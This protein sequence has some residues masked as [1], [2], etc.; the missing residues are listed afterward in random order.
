VRYSKR[1]TTEISVVF[2]WYSGM[3][4]NMDVKE[5]A[6]KASKVIGTTKV[7]ATSI[8]H[9]DV[10]YALHLH[11]N[12][13][14]TETGLV[15]IAKL[16]PHDSDL[17]EFVFR[18]DHGNGELDV[19]IFSN[20]KSRKDWDELGYKGHHTVLVNPDGREYEADI[21]I[22]NRQIFKGVIKVGLVQG[23]VLNETITLTE[24]IDVQ[25]VD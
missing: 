17:P 15:T 16:V 2:L 9:K 23:L 5:F 12:V 13:Y 14:A 7:T 1:K 20:G 19:D 3:L 8:Q 21:S 10:G 22:H 6:D 4:D 18:W 25:I 11:S 24:H